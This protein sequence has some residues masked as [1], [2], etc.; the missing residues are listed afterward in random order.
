MNNIYSKIREQCIKDVPSKNIIFVYNKI[1]LST[2]I[3]KVKNIDSSLYFSGVTKKKLL[4]NSMYPVAIVISCNN[5]YN[6]SIDFILKY[7]IS[8]NGDISY[9]K[10]FYIR[11]KFKHT[12]NY[13]NKNLLLD[14]DLY[15]IEKDFDKIIN[16]I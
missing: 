1:E 9:I 13:I 15:K 5:R 10:D 8:K 16:E 3:D 12:I 14:E 6:L 4:L 2:V 7:L 11:N